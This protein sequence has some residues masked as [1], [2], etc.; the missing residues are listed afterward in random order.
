MA[1]KKA[2]KRENGR[3]T[4]EKGPGKLR[5]YKAKA[6]VG[7]KVDKNGKTQVVYKS[8]GN[9][10]TRAEAEDALAEF[11]KNPYDISLSVKTFADLYN[12]WSKQYF[13]SLQGENSVRTITSAYAYCSDLYNMPIRNIG[14]GHIKDGWNR[15]GRNPA[16]D[17]YGESHAG[18][19]CCRKIR[20]E[21]R[22]GQC[23]VSCK[24]YRCR[25]PSS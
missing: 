14:P 13:D 9:F 22:C 21:I 4:V 16:G 1:R 3:G 18:G 2:V 17:Q 6:P 23:I 24:V 15:R 5:P 8:L 20:A 10:T 25:I 11:S 7:T 19:I 12:V